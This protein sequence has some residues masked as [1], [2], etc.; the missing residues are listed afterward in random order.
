MKGAHGVTST[1]CRRLWSLSDP[2]LAACCWFHPEERKQITTSLS[3]AT[4]AAPPWFSSKCPG[5]LVAPADPMSR[6]GVRTQPGPERTSNFRRPV[7]PSA[8]E[9]GALSPELR[10]NWNQA[11]LEPLNPED[12][13]LACGW[14]TWALVLPPP[15]SQS[16][17]RKP[18]PFWPQ[19]EAP[20]AVPSPHSG[21][22]RAQATPETYTWSITTRPTQGWPRA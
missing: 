17:R 22:W 9:L 19:M 15:S 7:G 14:E 8:S 1:R 13:S 4:S 20:R 6:A 21:C 18:F 12:K 10:F 11:G 2:T 3:E 16:R 5:F